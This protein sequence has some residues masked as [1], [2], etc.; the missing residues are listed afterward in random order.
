METFDPVINRAVQRFARGS[1]ALFDKLLNVVERPGLRTPQA[2]ADAVGAQAQVV[3]P[4]KFGEI[5]FGSR[6]F[7]HGCARLGGERFVEGRLQ[8]G[9]ELR[10]PAAGPA[11]RFPHFLD[12]VAFHHTG[13]QPPHIGLIFRAECAHAFGDSALQI[14]AGFRQTQSARFAFG[15][16]GAG[17]QVYQVEGIEVAIV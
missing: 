14:N 1:A 11:M 17:G 16:A 6:L 7:G 12:F 13:H 4:G 5:G 9:F 8:D 10:V 2:R 3:E 15:V